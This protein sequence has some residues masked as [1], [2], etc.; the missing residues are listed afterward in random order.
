MEVPMPDQI[1]RQI[2]PADHLALVDL[3]VAL[4][5][6]APIIVVMVQVVIWALMIRLLLWMVCRPTE[7]GKSM[8]TTMILPQRK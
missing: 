5:V 1:S 6:A 4:P 2:H 8:K 7:M 3:A